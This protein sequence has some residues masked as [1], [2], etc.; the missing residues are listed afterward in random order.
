MTSPPDFGD[1]RPAELAGGE[2]DQPQPVYVNPAYALVADVVQQLAG[3]RVASLGAALEFD[4]PTP[5]VESKIAPL[6]TVTGRL[7]P[8]SGADPIPFTLE[9]SA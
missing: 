3:Q 7:R 6:V 1:L 5:A 9:V 4:Q 8:A 2:V